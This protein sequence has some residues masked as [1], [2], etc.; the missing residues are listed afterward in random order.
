MI[1]F[2]VLRGDRTVQ[3]IA[4]KHRVHLLPAVVFLETMRG[5]VRR[6]AVEDWQVIAVLGTCRF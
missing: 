3:E 4:A 5:K 2:E 6:V 1:P